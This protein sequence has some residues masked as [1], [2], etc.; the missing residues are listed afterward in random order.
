MSEPTIRGALAR[1]LSRQPS[2]T[3]PFIEYLASDATNV[4]AR[5]TLFTRLIIAGVPVSA[6]ASGTTIDA[7]IKEGE[8]DRA[9]SYYAAVHPGEDRHRS[10]DPRFA[11]RS[12][13]PS[14]LEWNPIE[15]SGSSVALTSDGAEISMVGGG[16]GLALRQLQ[17]LPPG[18]YRLEGRGS[19]SDQRKEMVPYWTLT[20]LNGVELGRV[21]LSGSTSGGF[22]ARLVVPS[23]CPAQYL[24]LVLQPTDSLAGADAR[25]KW[26]QLVPVR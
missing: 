20:C 17:L 18:N 14:L 12:D 7:L 6:S 11:A 15:A 5:A 22:A 19:I 9:W 3:Q 4:S 1:T 2:W 23:G 13:T 26:V 10:R 25:I 16:G 21:F 8:F 24:S